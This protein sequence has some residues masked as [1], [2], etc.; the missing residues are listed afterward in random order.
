MSDPADADAEELDQMPSTSEEEQREEAKVLA[1][2]WLGVTAV[3]IFAVLL[4]AVG[5]LQA[6][7]LVDLFPFG[8]NWTV[9]WFVLVALGMVVVA[10][11]AWT[12]W[13]DRI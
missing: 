7:G 9:E 3:S 5:L 13:N 6:S 10:M 1:E 4:I 11:V 8:S 12:W 2:G